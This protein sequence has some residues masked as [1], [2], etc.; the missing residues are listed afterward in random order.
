MFPFRSPTFTS[1]RTDPMARTRGKCLLNVPYLLLNFAITTPKL[2][3]YQRPIK[4]V[5]FA[6]PMQ[7]A[8]PTTQ[9]NPRVQDCL[10]LPYV[11]FFYGCCAVNAKHSS[12]KVGLLEVL[13]LRRDPCTVWFLTQKRTVGSTTTAFL[14]KEGKQKYIIVKHK[15]SS[16]N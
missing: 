14:S 3:N 15:D 11:G 5:G 1:H 2:S 16:L 8:I 4:M 10:G 6:V 13:F 7:A 9:W 12:I